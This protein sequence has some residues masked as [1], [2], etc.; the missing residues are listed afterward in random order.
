MLSSLPASAQ[1]ATT[2]SISSLQALL[3]S[4]LAQVQALQAQL[5]VVM[6]S[7]S[8]ISDTL[9]LISQLRE[10][11]SGDN[12]KLLQTILA[13]D[14][15]VYPEGII[16]GYFGKL[17]ANAVRH[18]QKKYGLDQVG[19]VG[20]K[21]LTKLNEELDKNPVAEQNDEQGVKQ[22]CAIVPPGHLIAPGWLR[23]QGGVEP[24]VPV[25]QTLPPGILSKLGQGQEAST[26]TPD[27]V[28]RLFL[29]FRLQMS[30]QLR[31]I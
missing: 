11:A 6:Q 7:Q 17:T 1:T 15:D 20:P 3:E 10:G 9:K 24:I 13:S 2:T 16:S 14:S 23:K 28:P 26:S 22:V 25:C 31:H 12:V 29:G 21:T 19:F 8:E 4:L 18:F 30:L 27:T 5:Q